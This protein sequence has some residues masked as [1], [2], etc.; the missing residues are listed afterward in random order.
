MNLQSATAQIQRIW[1]S[2]SNRQKISIGLVAAVV[3]CCLGA[4]A[5]FRKPKDFSPLFS[6][7]SAED[8]GA[9]VAK[10][11][12]S[13]AEYR[14]AENGGTILVPSDRVAELRLQMA[15]AGIPRTGRIG[16][17]LFDKTNL[18]ASDFAEQV[19]YRRALEGELERSVRSI[20]EVEQARIHLTFAKESVFTESRLPAKASVLLTLRSGAQITPGNVKAIIHLVASAV[21]G[22]TPEGVS[23]S[24]SSGDL[25]S[26][27]K[28]PHNP[29][30]ASDE[31]I[32]YR[33]KLERDLIAKVN[34][35]LEPL[36]GVGKF[37]V[38]ISVDCDFSSGEQSE[39]LYDPDKSVML[40]S[41]KS[42][43]M[44]GANTSGGV[45]GTASNLPRPQPRAAGSVGGLTRRSENVT[46]QTSRTVRRTKLPQG[47]I[48]RLSAS[49]LLDQG[50]RWELQGGRQQR[51]L[52]PATPENILAI[53]ELVSATVGLVPTRGDQLV[54][55]SL[56][57]E[58]TLEKPAPPLPVSADKKTEPKNSLPIPQVNL[59]DWRV[60][61]GAGVGALLLIA[62]ALFLL[63]RK[64]R[65]K[66]AVTVGTTLPAPE[67]E[68]LAAPEDNL[69]ENA[70]PSHLLAKVQ[71]RLVQTVRIDTLAEELRVGILSDPALAA[72]VLRT[73]LDEGQNKA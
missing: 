39:E 69:L 52:V 12:E 18:G 16:F 24:D 71:Q 11:K 41:Q 28:K 55:Q 54:V 62:G 23:V 46:Y 48:K 22:L 17:E 65:K 60:L 14:V 15:T 35:T 26:K 61:A 53:R 32:E 57:F 5:A 64:K 3:V 70:T 10:L 7:M 9:V 73:W 38:G 49:V 19:N 37:R 33:Q 1:T 59:Q 47:S 45:P 30:E 72:R 67:T 56:A 2:L 58:S 42:E 6:G 27:D 50:V 21:E 29:D 44:T 43:E 4:F 36:L 66:T 8:G 13:T 68:T 31:L 25:L 40:T 34:T 63:K 51:I 20:T